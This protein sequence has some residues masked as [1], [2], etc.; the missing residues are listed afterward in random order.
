[1]R[2]RSA[3][4]LVLLLA[5][6]SGRNEASGREP[7]PAAV[8][9]LG[10]L[11]A[12][13]GVIVGLDVRR[14]GASALARRAADRA[15][16][17]D[18]LIE[19]SLTALAGRCGLDPARD[20]ETVL[21]G[22]APEGAVAGSVMVARGKLDPKR[23]I[24]CLGK[25]LAEGGGALE[26]TTVA[27]APAWSVRTGAAGEPP[28]V[29]ITFGG[30]QTLIMTD[31]EAWL[32]KARD[33]AA[34]KAKGRADLMGYVGR[35]D[36]A[37]GIWLVA[38]LPDKAGR[39]LVS[40]ADG[41]VKGPAKAIYGHLDLT[42]GLAAELHVELADADDAQRAVAHL[43]KQ[44]PLLGITARAAGMGKLVT[45]VRLETDGAVV[46]ARLQLDA[47]E[48]AEIEARIGRQPPAEELDK[49]GAPE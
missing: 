20:L 6:C 33:P 19:A 42:G 47:R 27:G 18:P 16:L 43:R 17:G 1:M 24:D 45:N 15:L 22:I 3:L 13:V 23:L 26:A 25:V 44:L 9:G 12:E 8:D 7:S 21:L 11:P 30:P 4:L 41:A 28:R 5:A 39:R 32:E 38:V 37:K 2:R 48:L 46:R 40:A 10:A 14:L 49:E 35:I 29:W 36:T 34:P 31:R